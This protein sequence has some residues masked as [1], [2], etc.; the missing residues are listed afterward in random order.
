MSRVEVDEARVVVVVPEEN[1]PYRSLCDGRAKTSPPLVRRFRG[2][3]TVEAV[4]RASLKEPDAQFGMV[5]PSLL[6]QSVV[7]DSPDGTAEW[8]NYWRERYG[9]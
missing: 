5:P 7:R 9:V 8:A 6:L 3:N 4:M 1:L 2:L